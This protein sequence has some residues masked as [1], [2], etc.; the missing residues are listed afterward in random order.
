MYIE[1]IASIASSRSALTYIVLRGPGKWGEGGGGGLD[2]TAPL[3]NVWMFK[4]TRQ[5]PCMYEYQSV[6]M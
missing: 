2:P 3:M 4:T 6:N 1:H 5:L